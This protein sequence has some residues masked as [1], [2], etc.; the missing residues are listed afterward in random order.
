MCIYSALQADMRLTR[1]RTARQMTSDK[2]VRQILT[3]RLFFRFQQIIHSGRCRSNALLNRFAVPNLA[4][5]GRFVADQKYFSPSPETV[6]VAG[7]GQVQLL[8]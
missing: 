3:S 8:L 2:L 1:G 5:V 7:V 4:V 6:V